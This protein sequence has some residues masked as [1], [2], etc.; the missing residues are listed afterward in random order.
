[1]LL[2]KFYLNFTFKLLIYEIR[3]FNYL[4]GPNKFKA[5]NIH[6]LV[7]KACGS[8]CPRISYEVMNFAI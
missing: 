4:I 1:M 5:F 7:A 3:L 8:S 2:E 6:V